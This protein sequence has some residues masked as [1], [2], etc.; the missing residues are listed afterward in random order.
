MSRT[1][2]REGRLAR[3]WRRCIRHAA[4]MVTATTTSVA[5]ATNPR[6]RG[7]SGEARSGGAEGK[8]AIVSHRRL[9]PQRA[10]D[11][12]ISPLRRIESDDPV[13]WIKKLLTARQKKA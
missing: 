2:R 12:R 10:V 8:G 5:A 13:I 1:L 9:G 4:I 11:S 6:R 3:A 7:E